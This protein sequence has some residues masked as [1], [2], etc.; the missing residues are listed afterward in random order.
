MKAFC[1]CLVPFCSPSC[2][3]GFRLFHILTNTGHHPS[4]SDCAELFYKWENERHYPKK[5]WSFYWIPGVRRAHFSTDVCVFP[6]Q[7]IDAQAIEEFYG[8]TSDISKNS[9]SGY[10]LFY[11]S[12]D[13]GSC[14]EERLSASFLLWLFGKRSSTDFFQEKRTAGSSGGQQRTLHPIKQRLWVNTLFLSW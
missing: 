9:E 5:D 11:Q 1:L 12:R 14:D 10:I 3:W 8:L 4:H 6:S 13:W 7:K 2:E